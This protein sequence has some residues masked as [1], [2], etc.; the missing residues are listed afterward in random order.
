MLLH[1]PDLPLKNVPATNAPPNAAKSSTAVAT[2]LWS[3]RGRRDATTAVNATIA[4]T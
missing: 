2:P 4:I 1:Q 3:N